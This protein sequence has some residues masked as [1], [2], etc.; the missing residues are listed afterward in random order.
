MILRLAGSLKRDH[1]KGPP[2]G[3]LSASRGA[4]QNR[5]KSSYDSSLVEVLGWMGKARVKKLGLSTNLE[6]WEAPQLAD[7]V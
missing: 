6:Y 2:E 1:L 4:C 5:T 3:C 7:A